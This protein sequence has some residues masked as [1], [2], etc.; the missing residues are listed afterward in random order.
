M[1]EPEQRKKNEIDTKLDPMHAIFISV[2]AVLM[3]L[4]MVYY[5]FMYDH[6]IDCTANNAPESQLLD[7]NCDQ[8]QDEGDERK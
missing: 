5:I 7:S 2:V 3:F 1:E 6:K 8:I 4:G